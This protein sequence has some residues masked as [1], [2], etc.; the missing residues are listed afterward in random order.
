M[1]RS[2]RGGVDMFVWNGGIEWEWEWNGMEEKEGMG[3]WRKGKVPPY[4]QHAWS[5]HCNVE[6][7]GWK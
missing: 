7:V 3:E 5:D 2:A 1:I 6:Q 4:D